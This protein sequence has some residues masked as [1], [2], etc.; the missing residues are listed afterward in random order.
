MMPSW[1][2]KH[3]EPRTE[4]KLI[5]GVYYKYAVSYRY[6]KE[7]K[8]TSKITGH[9]L[10]KITESG[11]AP[12]DKDSLRK[13][14]EQIPKIDTKTY[15]IY[16]LFSNLLSEEI[17]SLK[18]S[19]GAEETE[20]LLIFSMMRFAHQ[21]PI[22]RVPHYY[23]TDIC[24]LHWHRR[25]LTEKAISQTLRYFGQKREEVVEWMRSLLDDTEKAKTNFVMMD[26]THVPCLSE[27]LAVN[28]VGNSS[29]NYDPQIRLMYIFSSLQQQPVY[30]RLIKGNITDS[31][32][33]PLCLKEFGAQNVVFVADKGFF[34]EINIK[35]LDGHDMQYIIPLRRNNPMINYTSPKKP[36]KEKADRNYFFY[37]NRPIWYRQYECEGKHLITFLD[38]HLRVNE[39]CDY[40][41]R[42]ETLPEE[43]T[44]DSY[45]EK[46]N[47]F[48]T[49]T[50]IYKT[51][52]ELKPSEIYETYK[53]RNE[54]EVMFDSYKSYLD[55]DATWMQDIYVMEGWLLANFIAMAAYYKL[56]SRLKHAYLK[57]TKMLSK[58]SPKDI[59]E[60]SKSVWV[61]RMGG[62]WR[63]SENTAKERELFRKIGVEYVK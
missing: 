34:C 1:V 54:I 50:M 32:S 57:Q 31:S 23:A 52:H 24:S 33:M 44:Y 43:Y 16:H 60:M 13:Q 28:A 41:R 10:G 36:S 42:M 8:R 22:K 39:D 48:G 62:E 38:E 45:V 3:R 2:L 19:F 56:S 25:A 35:L 59:V 4:I 11:F 18:A 29:F 47:R 58:Y 17:A 53:Q 63:I 7:K 20:K 21:S 26:S 51:R 49:L 14:G 37:Q 9:L 30:Y 5:N 15:G 40:L 12:S 46:V 55:A 6:D 27:K 61:N